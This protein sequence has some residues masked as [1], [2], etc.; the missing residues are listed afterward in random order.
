MFDGTMC[1]IGVCSVGYGLL[2]SSRSDGWNSNGMDQVSGVSTVPAGGAAGQQ[3]SLQRHLLR[4]VSRA[5]L[6]LRIQPCKS[7]SRTCLCG[8]SCL[9][10]LDHNYGTAQSFGRQGPLAIH[11][12]AFHGFGSGRI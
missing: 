12:S 11:S 2:L 9:A 5:L 4:M 10:D 3:S 8:S 1:G 6:S 7:E